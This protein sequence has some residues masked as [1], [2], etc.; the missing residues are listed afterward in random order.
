MAQFYKNVIEHNMR[1]LIFSTTFVR[2][3]SHSKKNWAT[4]D[5]KKYACLHVKKSFFLLDFNKTWIFST[6]FRKILKYLISRKSVRWEPCCSMRVGRKTWQA[7][8]VNVHTRTTHSAAPV[9]IYQTT[10]HEK[11]KQVA[12]PH[13]SEYMNHTKQT[14]EV[15]DSLQQAVSDK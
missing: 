15:E 3:I 1:V 5:Q 6:D 12:P 13:S 14:S 4:Y 8:C 2:N 11:H 7:V 9:I 10:K